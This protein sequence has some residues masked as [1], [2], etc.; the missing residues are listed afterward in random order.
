MQNFGASANYGSVR[1][2][3]NFDSTKSNI[4]KS[5]SPG[6]ERNPASE[7]TAF[8]SEIVKQWVESTARSWE[9]SSTRSLKFGNIKGESD[10]RRKMSSATRQCRYPLD[11]LVLLMWTLLH[12]EQ[13]RIRIA[14]N[15]DSSHQTPHTWPIETQMQTVPAITNLLYTYHLRYNWRPTHVQNNRLEPVD[16]MTRQTNW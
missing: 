1:K 16:A 6:K 2:G 15:R 13:N 10:V 12:C 9:S 11:Q 14:T 3:S 7:T 8:R 4:E 5:S